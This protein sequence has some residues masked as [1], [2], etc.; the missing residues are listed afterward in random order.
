MVC[1]CG[2]VGGGGGGE[3]GILLDG[4]LKQL[5]DFIPRHSGVVKRSDE[6]HRMFRDRPDGL[7]TSLKVQPGSG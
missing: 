6:G 5:L 4:S 2:G 3:R 7:C 1:V